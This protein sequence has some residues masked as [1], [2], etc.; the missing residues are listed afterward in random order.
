MKIDELMD[1]IQM[2]Y[3]QSGDR[4]R[5]LSNAATQDERERMY[6]WLG[7]MTALSIILDHVRRSEDMKK[8]PELLRKRKR[9]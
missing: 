5:E 8:H 4:Y 6:Y 1:Y 2:E 9:V 3:G 7:R